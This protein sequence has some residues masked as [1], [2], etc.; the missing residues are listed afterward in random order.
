MYNRGIYGANNT[1]WF[2]D[3]LET[4]FGFRVG[5]SIQRITNQGFAPPAAPSTIKLSQAKPASFNVGAN[6]GLLSWLRPYAEFS[7]SFDPPLTEAQDPYGN[8]PKTSQ[9]VGEE[10]GFKL[11]NANHTIS[12]SLAAY[13]TNSKNEEYLISSTLLHDINPSG[14]NGQF[15]AGNQWV[16]VNRESQGLELKL[17]AQPSR[18]WRMRLSA[19]YTNGKI[20]NSVSYGQLYNDQFNENS[21]GQVTYANGTVVYV[22]GAATSSGTA[23]E[24]SPT[25]AGAIPLTATTLMS[26]STS[27]YFANPIS[28]TG[29]ITGSTA[30]GTIIK[31]PL[32]ASTQGPILTGATG[33]PIS[34]IQINASAN[35]NNAGYI[36][37]PGVIPTVAAGDLTT[38]YPVYTFNFTN[39][40]Q[41]R[42]GWM[43]GFMVGGTVSSSW[44]NRAY[45]YYPTGLAIN[46]A[47][48]MYYFPNLTTFNGILGYTRKFRGISWSTQLNVNNMFNHYDIIVVP[49]A[50]NG[51]ASL[52][53]LNAT[54]NAQPRQYV[55]TNTFRF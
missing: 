42:D 2:G 9:G 40:Y 11:A 43:R 35:P 27:P 39:V 25:T 15:G 46:A 20:A 10:I 45:Y 44:D 36:A 31:T 18:D 8:L 13:H 48:V 23:K 30:V 5:Q 51:Y 7:D 32:F 24:V 50:I 6:Y 17:T 28:I 53:S 33:L 38:G 16:N 37:P 22:N 19:A 55:W 14:L 21:Q 41:P 49:N 26:T 12:G 29:Q 52:N 47:R 3:R 1:Q 34:A 4:L 54:W